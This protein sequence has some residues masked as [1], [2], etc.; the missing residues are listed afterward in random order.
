MAYDL[1]HTWSD[2]MTRVTQ[3]SRDYLIWKSTS[4]ELFEDLRVYSSQFANNAAIATHLDSKEQVT[5]TV[6]ESHID[7][8]SAALTSMRDIGRLSEGTS[9]TLKAFVDDLRKFVP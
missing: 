3:A 8:L 9:V 4:A 6:T 2:I 7:D 5:G 1:D